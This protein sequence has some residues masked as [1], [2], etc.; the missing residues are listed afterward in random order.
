MVNIRIRM[1]RTYIQRDVIHRIMQLCK[2]L[3]PYKKG[4]RPI[5]LKHPKMNR[6]KYRYGIIEKKIQSVPQKRIFKSL[7]QKKR[8]MRVAPHSPP[9]EKSFLPSDE[10]S[11]AQRCARGVRCGKSRVYIIRAAGP[12]SLQSGCRLPA[13]GECGGRSFGSLGGVCHGGGAL[14]TPVAV[15]SCFSPHL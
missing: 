14:Y 2:I 1:T 8:K 11:R 15:A 5:R 12:L 4:L 3:S 7:I 13:A 6:E 9:L 10:V